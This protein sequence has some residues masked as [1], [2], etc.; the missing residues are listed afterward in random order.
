MPRHPAPALAVALLLGGCATYQPDAL[1][2]AAV[3]PTALPAASHGQ[4]LPAVLSI[5]R[6]GRLAIENNPELRAARAEHGIA[7]AQ[8]E[9][10]AALPNPVLSASYAGVVSGPGALPAIALGLGQD[11]KA[12]IL[13]PA[14]MASAKAQVEQVDAGILWQEWQT[15]TKAELTALEMVTAQRQLPYA[16]QTSALWDERTARSRRALAAGDI[17]QSAY[18]IESQLAADAGAQL[19]ALEVVQLT[20]QQ[21]LAGL[22]GLESG[23]R[24]N[25]AYPENI[26]PADPAVVRSRQQ[27]LVD[28]R[29]DLLAL[30][31]GYQ[32][33]EQ[34]VRESVLAQFPAMT[35][36]GNAGRDT[37]NVKTAGLDISMELPL[38]N[39]NQSGISLEQATRAKLKA[40]F[41]A[42]LIAATNEVSALLD[43]QQLLVR[44]QHRVSAQVEQ[45][46]PLLPRLQQALA[47]QDVEG[48]TYLDAVMAQ[49]AREQELIGITSNIAAQN[50]AIQTL[51]GLGMPAMSGNEDSSA[52]PAGEQP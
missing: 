43:Q 33:Q 11:I 35:L 42:R 49:N 5:P 51:A 34:R 48:R 28:F 21:E 9:A 17:T 32:A 45:A 19:S 47:R 25:V 24:L 44:Q 29:P 3:A 23:V 30:R 22:L 2:P 1:N 12:L 6:I 40:E 39:H 15:A 52:Q 14:K 26:Q 41:D 20:R 18:V 4:P 37:G 31:A 27:H 38:F 13:R 7:A 10:A 46:R 50:L 8:L 36:G 16:R